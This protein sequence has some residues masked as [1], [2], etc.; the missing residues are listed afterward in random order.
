MIYLKPIKIIV[1][2]DPGSIHTAHF[3]NLLHELRYRVK[4]FQCE[5]SYCQNEFL[6]NT[7]LNVAFP[8]NE[9]VNGNVLE[10]FS[11]KFLPIADF[12]RN[13]RKLYKY[14]VRKIERFRRQGGK[15]RAKQLV[16]MIKM[17]R[18]DLII[19]LKM[20]NDG[21]TVL[22]AKEKL[23]PAFLPKWLHFTWGSDLEYFAKNSKMRKKHLP[24]IKKLLNSCDY[25]LADSQ[26]DVEQ[27]AQFGLKG[28]NLGMFLATGGFNLQ[29]MT[30]LCQ[31]NFKRDFILIKGRDD[32]LG[33]KAKNILKALSRISAHL[34]PY[35][36][37]IIYYNL[38]METLAEE[39]LKKNKIDYELVSWI[40]YKNILELFAKS[41]LTIAASEIEGTP[42]FLL[43]SM[44]LGALP[45]HSDSETIKDW[46]THGQ[47]GLLFPAN[48]I[49]KLCSNLK[50][51]LTDESLFKK[52]QK[53]NWRIA[54]ERMNRRIMRKRMRNL[55]EKE[56][57]HDKKIF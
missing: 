16:K 49:D 1:V 13:H 23:D 9:A 7:T 10:G 47:N 32:D 25:F 6:K 30:K 56:I 43:E 54:K 17:W 20:Q 11:P 57:L 31:K 27:A 41:R 45:I 3:V 46:I 8:Y 55:I 5:Y 15:K 12:I 48:D 19:S 28:K 34:K 44:T 26:R 24:K 40:P 29:K 14:F 37:K 50:I 22:A 4:I 18:P 39:M 33:G 35:K 2:G 36:I 21:Y 53:I 51:A 38:K 42:S 52:A